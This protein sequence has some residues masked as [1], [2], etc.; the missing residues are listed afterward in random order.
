VVFLFAVYWAGLRNWFE[1][2]DFAWLGLHTH[3]DSFST[4][5]SAMFTPMAQG[6]IRPWSERGFFLL[7]YALFQSN[8]LP[9][10]IAVFVTQA[11]NLVLLGLIMR[12]LTGSR[13]VAAA[14]PILWTANFALLTPLCWVSDYNQIQCAFFL[15]LA[16]LLYL[17]DR[18]WLQVAVFLLGFGA[19]ELNIVYPA[20]VLAYV[21][22]CQFSRRRILQTL[23]LFAVSGAYYLLHTWAAPRQSTGIY[24]LHLDKAIPATLW[25][26]WRWAI[27]AA[28]SHLRTF[29]ILL[30]TALLIGFVAYQA[31]RKNRLPLFF[32]LWFLITLSPTLP[33]RDHISDYYLAIPVVGLGA[34]L[35]LAIGTP[36]RTIRF[37]AIVPVALYLFLH[38]PLARAGTHWYMGHTRAV[39][40]LVWGV[41]HARELHPGKTILLTDISDDLYVDAIAH[42]VFRT[43]DISDVYLAPELMEQVD[44]LDKANPDRY[45]YILP[46]GPT[47]HALQKEILIVYSARG[48]HLRN[49]TSLYERAAGNRYGWDETKNLPRRLDAGSSLMAYLL[50]STWY[51]P[52][53]TFRWMP[54]TASF[55]IGGPRTFE[56]KLTLAGYCPPEQTESGP[57]VFSVAVDGKVISESTISKPETSFSRTFVLPRD[58]VGR[59]SVE[60]T[61]AVNRTLDRTEG[62]P[63]GLAFGV[64]EIR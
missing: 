45:S 29:P 63:L 53:G 23:P 64:F 12:K 57:L 19:L 47:I 60:V 55:R 20:I 4:F 6:T 34:I 16:F 50:G 44:R 30:F 49:I 58:L 2:D 39:R 22:T 1:Q 52:V 40:S 32:L 43:L 37:A 41:R 11:A 62:S 10:H 18:Y 17:H 61:I 48:E 31:K 14:A 7:F 28:N 24:A 15:L 5:L 3:V 25:T 38:V 26:Y 59:E 54:S 21:V 33:L 51:S 27:A 56:D 8:A 9:Y 36:S 13:L 42:S 46:A 35:A